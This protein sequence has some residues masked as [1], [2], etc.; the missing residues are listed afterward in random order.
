VVELRVGRVFADLSEDTDK[1]LENGSV[2]GK[3]GLTSS[4]DDTHSGCT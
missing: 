2:G 4:D 3:E 1:V